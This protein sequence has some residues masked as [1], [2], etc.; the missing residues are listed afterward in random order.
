MFKKSGFTLIE[1]VIVIILLGILGATA[2]PKFVGN[3]GFE[4]QAY[5][6]Q[7]LQ[8]LKTVQ[9]QAM[10]CDAD[11]RSS[12]TTNLYACNKVVIDN[13]RFG[14]P[15]ECGASLPDAYAVPHLGM[16]L[17]EANSSGLTFF[18]ADMSPLGKVMTDIEFN[19]LGIVTDCPDS[20]TISVI[21]AQTLTIIIESQ[22]YVHEG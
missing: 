3:D 9:Q 5:R 15:D 6:D 18:L 2:I 10:S 12:R 21:G 20:C 1:L 11:C 7:L 19:S 14:I 13:N 4:A 17:A 22:G 8:L 16:S